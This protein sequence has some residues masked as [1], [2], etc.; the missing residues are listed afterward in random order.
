MQTKKIKKAEYHGLICRCSDKV[1]TGTMLD[2]WR[3]KHPSLIQIQPKPVC[4]HDGQP[5]ET[6]DCPCWG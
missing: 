2:H 3:R 1:T 4:L 6:K 5:H